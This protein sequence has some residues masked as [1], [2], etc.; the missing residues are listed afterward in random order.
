MDVHHRTSNLNLNSFFDSPLYLLV[1]K[2]V[3]AFLNVI[4]YS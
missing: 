3:A 2:S 4:V 1:S